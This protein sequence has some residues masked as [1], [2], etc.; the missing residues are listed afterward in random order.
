PTKTDTI[1]FTSGNTHRFER[2]ACLGSSGVEGRIK[3][4]HSNGL[5][6]DRGQQLEVIGMDDLIRTRKSRCHLCVVRLPSSM[7][8]YN[9]TIMSTCTVR[10][11][12]LPVLDCCLSP[13]VSLTGLPERV[14]WR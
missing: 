12:R 11:R 9:L 13:L 6:W 3:V 14:R 10:C 2:C 7:A 1:T 4:D 8:P 5:I